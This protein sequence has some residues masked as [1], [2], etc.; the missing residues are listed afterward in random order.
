MPSSGEQP[1]EIGLQGHFRANYNTVG[2]LSLSYDNCLLYLRKQGSLARNSTKWLSFQHWGLLGFSPLSWGLVQLLPIETNC[3]F[4]LWLLLFFTA[5]PTSLVIPVLQ[6]TEAGHS[7]PWHPVHRAASCCGLSQ[8]LS[9]PTPCSCYFLQKFLPSLRGQQTL[10]PD[11]G[12]F[13]SLAFEVG[14]LLCYFLLLLNI[15]RGNLSV[16]YICF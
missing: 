2:A 11:F 16:T 13:N 12:F 15:L 6:G 14:L 3:Y 5:D 8:E 9:P 7:D 1:L 10:F 4:C